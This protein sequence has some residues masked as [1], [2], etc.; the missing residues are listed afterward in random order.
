MVIRR[1]C[2]PLDNHHVLVSSPVIFVMTK[3]TGGT[4]P[5]WCYSRKPAGQLR[6]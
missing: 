5:L 3:H 1:V 4:F 2:T 6:S